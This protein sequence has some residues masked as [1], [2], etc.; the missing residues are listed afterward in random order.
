MYFLTTNNDRQY[1]LRV[2]LTAD[3]GVSKYAEYSYFTV[4]NE[5]ANYRIQIGTYSGSAGEYASYIQRVC[6][7][8]GP[9]T[10]KAKDLNE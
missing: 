7:G 3:T 8:E 6:V 10:S 5:A 9:T 2:D 4:D 1:R